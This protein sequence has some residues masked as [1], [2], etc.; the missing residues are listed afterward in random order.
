M[1]WAK[2][3]KKNIFC[4][5]G[6]WSTDLKDKSSIKYIL[7]YLSTYLDI[8]AIHRHC[9]T[10]DSLN[11]YL[12][13]FTEAKYK[14]YSIIYLAFHGLP[15]QLHFS[16]SANGGDAF[17]ELEDISKT[18]K[19]VLRGKII[20]FGSCLTLN[21]DKRRINR[22][23]KE[24]KALAVIGYKESIDFTTSTALDMIVMETL[25]RNRDMRKVEEHIKKNYSQLSRMLK[26]RMVY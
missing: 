18:C 14:E 23:L 22:F 13:E 12:K 5:E 20:Y 4:L 7:D 15:N 17:V 8:D 11:Y 2:K 16:G 1:I 3:L 6:N 26:F 9:T 10:E 19:D 21:I 25:Q 24:T